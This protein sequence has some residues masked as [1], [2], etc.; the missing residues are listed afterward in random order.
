MIFTVIQALVFSQLATAGKHCG[1]GVIMDLKEGGWNLEGVMIKL[2]GPNSAESGTTDTTRQGFIHFDSNN[3]TA[4]RAEAVRR[5]AGMAFA[6]GS[7]VWV[8]SHNN[9]CKNATEIS[10][11]NY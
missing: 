6:M 5:I 9:S 8:Y 2:E 4:E 10:V 1:E 7:R 3:L 11:L